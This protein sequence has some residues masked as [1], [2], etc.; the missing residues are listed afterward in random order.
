MRKNRCLWFAPLLLGLSCA[1][2]APSHT[3]AH[4]PPAEHLCAPPAAAGP[5]EPIAKASVN[6]RPEV[7][8]YVIGDA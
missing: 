1:G 3:P 4:H 5:Q 8:Y 6:G 7:R 2:P